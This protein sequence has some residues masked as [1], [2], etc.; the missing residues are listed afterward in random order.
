M[1]VQ[2]ARQP[3]VG[4]AAAEVVHMVHADVGGEPAQD[5]RQ[6]VVRAAVQR[7]LVHGSSAGASAQNVSSN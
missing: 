7:R 5:V 4:D 1:V 3:I 6:I 2:H